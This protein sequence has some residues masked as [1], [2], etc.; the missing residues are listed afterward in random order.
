MKH[1]KMDAIEFEGL[2]VTVTLKGGIEEY[3]KSFLHIFN[4]VRESR[5]LYK[6]ENNYNNDV[7]VYCK[8]ESKEALIEYLEN[9]G[10]IKRTEM[11]LMYQ[12]TEDLEY[13]Y[14][15]YYEQTVVPYF[16]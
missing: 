12:L 7:T 16:E 6:V 9:F 3:A 8:P 15:K 1:L 13:D 10:E 4:N 11:V 14:E 5:E 2:A